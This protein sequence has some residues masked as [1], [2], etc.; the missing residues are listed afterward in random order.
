MVFNLL[1]FNN[2]FKYYWWLVHTRTSWGENWGARRTTALNRWP[3]STPREGVEILDERDFPD[4]PP[5]N[6]QCSEDNIQQTIVAEYDTWWARGDY[7]ELYFRVYH[8]ITKRIIQKIVRKGLVDA[9]H[10]KYDDENI[11]DTLTSFLPSGLPVDTIGMQQIAKRLHERRKNKRIS[12]EAKLQK[13]KERMEL[14]RCLICRGIELLLQ[15]IESTR[16]DTAINKRRKT[17]HGKARRVLLSRVDRDEVWANRMNSVKLIY[18]K[19]QEF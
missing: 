5:L 3:A 16:P 13:E 10:E 15:K 17:E 2:R 4:Q 6:R 19:I 9:N 14:T 18:I 11:V 8:S 7:L 12:E 1:E